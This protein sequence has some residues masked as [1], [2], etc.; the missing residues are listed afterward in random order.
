MIDKAYPADKSD[1]ETLNR[2]LAKIKYEQD[3]QLTEEDL[4]RAVGGI[5]KDKLYNNY[6][7]DPNREEW[8]SERLIMIMNE[9]LPVGDHAFFFAIDDNADGKPDA[10]WHDRM[11][12][13]VE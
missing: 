3:D 2:V 9:S 1:P 13:R 8:S 10:T 11:D 4:G 7:N 12:V 5:S 6:A